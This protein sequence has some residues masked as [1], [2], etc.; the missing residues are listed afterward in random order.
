MP[1][2]PAW[3]DIREAEVRIAK[4]GGV[5]NLLQGGGRCGLNFFLASYRVRGLKPTTNAARHRQARGPFHQLSSQSA[6][7]LPTDRQESCHRRRGRSNV[8]LYTVPEAW[9]CRVRRENLPGHQNRIHF[10]T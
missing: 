5:D 1:R 2:R 3:G 4:K 6:L 9:V 8:E 10:Q 7:A